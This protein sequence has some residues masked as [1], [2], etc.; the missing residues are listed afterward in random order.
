MN[1]TER[2]AILAQMWKNNGWYIVDLQQVVDVEICAPGFPV[3]SGI[4][5]AKPAA[6]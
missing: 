6:T 3:L 4:R 1:D 2:L 5:P